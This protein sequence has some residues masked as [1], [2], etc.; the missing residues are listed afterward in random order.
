MQRSRKACSKILASRFPI[1]PAEGTEYWEDGL[2]AEE[3][4]A[5][6]QRWRD[7][8]F[9]VAVNFRCDRGLYPRLVYDG[10]NRLL[11]PIRDTS[12]IYYIRREADNFPVDTPGERERV[13][14][15]FRPLL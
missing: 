4:E 14:A 7:R 11:D 12:E 13:E 15:V 6:V 2:T 8:L 3:R 9:M 1:P 10:Y 5:R